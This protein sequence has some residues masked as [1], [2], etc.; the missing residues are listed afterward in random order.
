[1]F[2]AA[3]DHRWTAKR[4]SLPAGA[5]SRC[6]E[7]RVAPRKSQQRNYNGCCTVSRFFNI[8][9]RELSLFSIR[10]IDSATLVARIPIMHEITKKALTMSTREPRLARNVGNGAACNSRCTKSAPAASLLV[11]GNVNNLSRVKQEKS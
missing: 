10:R 7:E 4:M 8:C 2:I 3:R 9:C 6:T 5:A 11:V 1:M